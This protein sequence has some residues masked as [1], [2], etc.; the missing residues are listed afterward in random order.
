[1]NNRS[2]NEIRIIIK[3]IDSIFRIKYE[4]KKIIIPKKTLNA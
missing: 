3:I 1:M 2:P 4:T